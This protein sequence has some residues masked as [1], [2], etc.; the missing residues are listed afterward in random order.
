MSVTL[1]SSGCFEPWTRS[2]SQANFP[3]ALATP[4]GEAGQGLSA[5]QRQRLALARVLI[6]AERNGAER[7]G[8]ER[9]GAEQRPTL[10]LLDEPTAHLDV[11]SER[12]VIDRLQSLVSAGSTVIAVAHREALIAAADRLVE[13]VTAPPERATAAVQRAAAVDDDGAPFAR[14]RTRWGRL[15]RPARFAAAVLLGAAAFLTGTALTATASWLIVRASDQ[16]P[17][18]TLSIAVV[19]VRGTAILKPLLR[20]FERL[21]SHDLALGT[22]A[23]W[24]ADLVDALA[25]RLPGTLTPRRGDLLTRLVRDVDDRLDG[26]LRGSLPLAAGVLAAAV[27]SAVAVAALPGLAVPLGVGLALAVVA[28]PLVAVAIDRADNRTLGGLRATLA[29]ALV[30]STDGLEELA[31]R[32]EVRD[33]PDHRSRQLARA[34]L[35]AAWRGGLGE[36]IARVG[37][38][39][40]VVGVIL[41]SATAWSAGQTSPEL[42]GILSL[43]SLTLAEP[44]LAIVP[45]VIAI[46][47][48]RAA[49]ARLAAVSAVSPAASEPV[50]ATP[51]A[52]AAAAVARAEATQLRCENVTVGWGTIPAV[53]G[54]D[55]TLAPGEQVAIVGAS[56]SGKSTLAAAVLRLLDPT[57]GTISLGGTPTGDLPGDTVRAR[58][59]ALGEFDHVFA[60]TLR[61]NLRF[62]RPDAADE[63]LEQALGRAGLGDW[64]TELPAG[65]DTWL[66]SGGLTLSGGE[67]RRLALSRALL[68]DAGILIL[69]EPTESLDTATARALMTDVLG[70]ARAAGRS[71]LLVTHRSEGL[72]QV[73]RVLRLT[74]GR[75]TDNGHEGRQ[76][77]RTTRHQP[78]RRPGRR[79][80][81]SGR[82]RARGLLRPTRCPPPVRRCTRRRSTLGA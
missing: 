18:L 77:G 11:D 79:Q 66:D 17:V 76:L 53:R 46:R 64:L 5:G 49:A 23:G 6:D 59:T 12:R 70:E 24:R 41:T 78:G 32:G 82:G 14:L 4:L 75:L 13:V 45:A 74:D 10:L 52:A 50:G 61:E 80:P 34:E 31:V 65:L 71:V 44:L 21:A 57:A 29:D 37:V 26:T 62:A 60:S 42:F 55:L 33:I 72:D 58:I 51:A 48:G 67:R 47:R 20:Y 81:L 35:R 19:M 56:G 68:R 40:V 22:L 63:D 30:E 16:P 9:N 73:D 28:G 3:A 39:V 8:A 7:N 54:V 43:A 2:A 15:R 36:A 27:A 38:A 1:T 25:I 69:D